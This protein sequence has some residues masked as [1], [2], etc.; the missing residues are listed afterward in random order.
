MEVKGREGK[1]DG[2]ELRLKCRHS[3][4]DTWQK[5]GSLSCLRSSSSSFRQRDS[6]LSFS[7]SRLT[8]PPS[9]CIWPSPRLVRPPAPEPQPTAVPDLSDGSQSAP[10]LARAR[11]SKGDQTL[12]RVRRP[13]DS[14]S[15]RPTQDRGMTP[16]RSPPRSRKWTRQCHPRQRTPQSQRVSTRLVSS[17]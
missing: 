5:L 6:L 14:P 17:A 3:P 7:P 12:Q 9:S 1:R 15:V 4:G 10:R 11:V 2:P 13:Y 8:H 16:P